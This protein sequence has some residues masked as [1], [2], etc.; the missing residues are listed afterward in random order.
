M[1]NKLFQIEKDMQIAIKTG[2][3]CAHNK[4]YILK[5]ATLQSLKNN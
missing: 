4:Y 2:D 5:M 3:N 1:Q